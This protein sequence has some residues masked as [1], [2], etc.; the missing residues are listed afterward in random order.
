[1]CH[2]NTTPREDRY[3]PSELFHRRKLRTYLPT[4]DDTVDINKGKASREITDMI[5]KNTSHTHKPLKAL[6]KGNLCYRREFDGKKLVKIDDLCEVIKV[7]KRGESY[8]IKDLET[9]RTYLRNRSWIK[10]CDKALN[11]IHKAKLLKVI[12]E[13]TTCHKSNNGS[14][15]KTQVQIPDPCIKSENSEPSHKRIKLDNSVVLA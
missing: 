1:M 4:L 6:E 3:S 14:I 8:Y 11:K 15:D 7:R 2:F 12:C 9:E 5:T 10:P 13:Q